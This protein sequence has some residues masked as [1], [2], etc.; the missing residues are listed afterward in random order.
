MKISI[1]TYRLSMMLTPLFLVTACSPDKGGEADNGSNLNAPIVDNMQEVPGN[2]SAPAVDNRGDAA[3]ALSEQANEAQSKDKIP[4]AIRGRWGLVAA[5][6]TSRNGDA[7][8]LVEISGTVL[9]FYES[10]G[11]LVSVIEW[12]PRRLHGDFDFEGEG[13]SWKREMELDLQPDGKVLVRRDHGED[14][15]PGPLRYRRCAA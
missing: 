11:T 10:R 6:C 14:S 2:A 4:L 5:D 9:S 15:I 8:G 12:T 3:A 7:K 1:F 13:M